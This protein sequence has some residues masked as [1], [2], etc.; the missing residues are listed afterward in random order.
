MNME[1]TKSRE[2]RNIGQV[3]SIRQGPSFLPAA[4]I[5]E[6]TEAYRVWLDMPGVDPKEIDINFEQGTLSVW[7]KVPPRHTER[8][9]ILSSEYGVG[10]FRRTFNL[11]DSIDAGGIRAEYD[12]GV[13]YLM[14]PKVEAAR[15]KKIAVRSK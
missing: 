2:R 8:A 11:T 1:M 3:E 5:Y 13:L 14:L 10:D 15:P 7:G 12:D 9:K 6:D 4:D